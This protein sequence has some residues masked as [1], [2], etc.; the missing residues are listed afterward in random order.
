MLTVGRYGIAIYLAET[1][2]ASTYGAAA[3]LL[4]ILFWVY[5]SALLLLLGAALTRADLVARGRPIVP[6]SSA[7]RVVQQQLL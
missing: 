2:I 5:F 4:V 7:V 6:R 3:S 1:A